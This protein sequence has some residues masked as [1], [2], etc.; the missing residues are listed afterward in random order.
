MGCQ[1]A[2]HKW[3]PWL[4]VMFAWCQPLSCSLSACNASAACCGCSLFVLFCARWWFALAWRCLM[5]VMYHI[6]HLLGRVGCLPAS[7]RGRLLLVRPCRLQQGVTR[8]GPHMLPC[9]LYAPACCSIIPCPSMS[10][11]S[12]LSWYSALPEMWSLGSVVCHQAHLPHMLDWA[13]RQLTACLPGHLQWT[14]AW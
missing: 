2:G 13:G 9:S 7:S 10:S 11:A 3:A 1:L 14:W 8:Q 12:Q 4:P 5:C 6:K